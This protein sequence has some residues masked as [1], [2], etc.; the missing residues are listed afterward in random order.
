M[1]VVGRGSM[2]SE[3]EPFLEN[4]VSE[5]SVEPSGGNSSAA[6]AVPARE[7]TAVPVVIPV[8]ESAAADPR[9]SEPNQGQSQDQDTGGAE[10]AP[11][12]SESVPVETSSSDA[13][14]GATSGE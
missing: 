11:N 7:D 8:H 12:P 10:A 5:P 14:A 13:G 4:S 1:S 2:F 9:N 6:S 3:A